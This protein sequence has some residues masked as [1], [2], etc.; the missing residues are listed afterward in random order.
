MYAQRM[1]VISYKGCRVCKGEHEQVI[2]DLL[3][4]KTP[5]LRIEKTMRAEPYN[6]PIKYEAVANHLKR[7]LNGD[8]RN[9][10]LPATVQAAAVAERR[11]TVG[12]TPEEEKDFALLVHATALEELKSGKLRISTKD[13]LTARALLDRRDE[14]KADRLMVMNLARLLSGAGG[15]GPQFSSEGELIEGV[16]KDVTPL[17]RIEAHDNGDLNENPLLAPPELR[18]AIG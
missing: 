18:E 15:V 2:N 9:I 1:P 11:L 13:G 3:A 4:R 14:K 17:G 16:F 8:L 12:M 10:E 7:C 6:F 5:M